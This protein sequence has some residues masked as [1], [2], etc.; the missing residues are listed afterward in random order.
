M[1][2]LENSD[3]PEVLAVVA[4]PTPQERHLLQR[5]C[6]EAIIRAHDLTAKSLVRSS[7]GRFAS[8]T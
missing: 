8:S 6:G 5:D 7:Q 2:N 4:L 1:S 3:E